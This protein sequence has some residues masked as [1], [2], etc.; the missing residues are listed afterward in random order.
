MEG[1]AKMRATNWST[2]AIVWSG[3]GRRARKKALA[4]AIFLVSGLEETRIDVSA[5]IAGPKTRFAG[6]VE[7]ASEET[8]DFKK[9]RK[10]P[11]LNLMPKTCERPSSRRENLSVW[12]PLTTAESFSKIR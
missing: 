11:G 3:P 4:A 5:L 9:G 7:S 8:E 2:R 6:A 10:P 12:T 1:S